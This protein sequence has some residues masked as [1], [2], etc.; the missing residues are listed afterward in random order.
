MRSPN[1]LVYDDAL[2]DRLFEVSNKLVG[3]EVDR[4]ARF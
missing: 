2:A 3:L 1:P 4:T